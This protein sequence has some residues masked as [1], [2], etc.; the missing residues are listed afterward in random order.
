MENQSLIDAAGLSLI[1]VIV[2]LA[3]VFAFALA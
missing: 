3:H 1:I 2:A